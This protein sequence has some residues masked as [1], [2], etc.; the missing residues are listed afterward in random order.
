MTVQQAYQALY[1]GALIVLAALLCVMLIRSAR[2]PGVTDRLLSINML[3]TL[4][5]AAILILS[6]LLGEGWL[7]DVALIY[8]MISFVSVLILARVYIPAHPRR[9][10]FRDGEKGESEDA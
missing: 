5:I 7:L 9:R 2:G 10:P 6:A 4:A 1:S 8:T 3:G